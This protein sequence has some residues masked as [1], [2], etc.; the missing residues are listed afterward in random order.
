ML[1]AGVDPDLHSTAI[2]V[3]ESPRLGEY[4]AVEALL[5]EAK[6]SK[7]WDA[8]R[9]MA[10]ALR[11]P[12]SAPIAGAAVETQEIVYTASRGKGNPRDLLQ[13][14]AVSG[15]AMMLFLDSDLYLPRPPDWKGSQPKQIN[16]GRTCRKLGWGYSL[17][18]GKSPY[19][20][21]TGTGRVGEGIKNFGSWKHLMDA[22]GLAI[23]AADNH[24]RR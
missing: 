6:G 21:P 17:K 11:I 23:H 16:Q 5:I 24:H 10:M 22:F 13:L 3:I 7:G 1:F 9:D 18:G 12:Q 2:A 20:V 15:A 4:R 8:V 19:C 14:A